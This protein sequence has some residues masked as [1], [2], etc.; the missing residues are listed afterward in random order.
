MSKRTKEKLIEDLGKLEVG[1]KEN[2]SNEQLLFEMNRK[3]RE[4]SEKISRL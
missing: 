1:I 2:Y 3:Y 4:I